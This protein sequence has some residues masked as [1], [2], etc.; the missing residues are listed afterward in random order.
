MTLEP[1][2]ARYPHL[3]VGYLIELKYLA[4]SESVDE[5]HVA[6]AAGEVAALPGRT[7]AWFASF[8]TSGSRVWRWCSTAGRWCVATRWRSGT[9]ST[10]Q[11]AQPKPGPGP[12][13]FRVNLAAG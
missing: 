6:T 9:Q 4:R 7:S 11:R 5:A 13:V 3:R 8:R 10:E 1:L 12:C 2:L